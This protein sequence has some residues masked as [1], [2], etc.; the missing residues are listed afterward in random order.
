MPFRLHSGL[1]GSS[2]VQHLRPRLACLASHIMLRS[3]PVPYWDLALRLSLSPC[4]PGW[5][6]LL[7]RCRTACRHVRAPGL[8]PCPRNRVP[9]HALG[10]WCRVRGGPLTC[11]NAG[12]GLPDDAATTVS[13]VM[14]GVKITPPQSSPAP[15]QAA[16][17]HPQQRGM[18]K[19][20]NRH[21]HDR[22]GQQS[23]ETD[24]AEPGL[25]KKQQRDA[26]RLQEFQEKKCK[27]CVA[28]WLPLVQ[29]LLRRSHRNLRDGVWTGWMRS[30]LA[31]KRL[32]S[33]FWRA[34]TQQSVECKET[35][36]KPCRGICT[37]AQGTR[38]STCSLRD[39]YIL[40]RARAFA[41]HVAIR[42]IRHS[43]RIS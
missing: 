23:M 24:G 5:F 2:P 42:T 11:P 8:P 41:T 18:R 40:Y 33:L 43:C 1:L 30:V 34:W 17:G 27:Q 14:H 19:E 21:V 20:G 28:H 36:E 35:V 10:H 6:N 32:R 37:G 38:L 4:R 29:A 13:L 39:V 26:A 12:H 3:C 7:P 31:R 22:Q 25:S 15:S 16:D 9:A